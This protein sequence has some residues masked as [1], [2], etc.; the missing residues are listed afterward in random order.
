MRAPPDQPP[1]RA[2]WRRCDDDSV[3]KVPPED[4]CPK[5]P[6]VTMPPIV[7][8][9]AMLWTVLLVAA[10][11]LFEEVDAFADW[12]PS[13]LGLLPFTTIWFG[14]AG[15]L[16]I[17]MQGTFTYN[18]RWRR[19]YDDWHFV[20]PILGAFMGTLGCLVFIVL[21]MPRPRTARP[22]MACSTP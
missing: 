12:F 14:A 19:S 4:D 3:K 9:V 16:L 11:L 21:T 15:G 18:H 2:V 10:F 1:Q 7:F 17:S 6:C 13:K 22:Q 20:P 8:I 5:D